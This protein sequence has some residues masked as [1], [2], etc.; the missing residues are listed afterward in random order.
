MITNTW[1]AII[2]V[3]RRIRLWLRKIGFAGSIS[4]Q[5]SSAGRFGPNETC[6]NWVQRYGWM[7]ATDGV[8]QGALLFYVPEIANNCNENPLQPLCPVFS[9]S[10][11]FALAT[12]LMVPRRR[13]GPM[14]A[15]AYTQPS[16]FGGEHLTLTSFHTSPCRSRIITNPK[17]WKNCLRNSPFQTFMLVCMHMPVLLRFFKW[18]RLHQH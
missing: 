1:N 15:L 11:V 5:R 8:C 16:A 17:C 14:Q 6:F 7:W 2:V 18:L 10:T 9:W 12:G 13:T 3:R 4:L